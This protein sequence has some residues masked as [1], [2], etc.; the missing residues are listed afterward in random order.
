ML[1]DKTILVVDDEPDVVDTIAEILEACRVDTAGTYR[2]GLQRLQSGSYDLVI[3]DIMGVS[4]LD[5]LDAAVQRDIPAVM[6]TAPAISPE[7]LL[8][9][10]ER[11]AI[12]FIP[13]HDLADL[14]ELLSEL[15]TVVEN[16]Q[17]PLLHTIKRLEPLLDEFFPPD[18]KV[19]CREICH[20]R[21]MGGRTPVKSSLHRGP[22]HPAHPAKGPAGATRFPAIDSD[23]DR[24]MVLRTLVAA[25]AAFCYL[26]FALQKYAYILYLVPGKRLT[27]PLTAALPATVSLFGQ[28]L[29]QPL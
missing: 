7:Y 5:L 27:R 19:K 15:L 2:T 4:G 14:N 11:G 22:N 26:T 13:K 25:L 12:S 1:R 28:N 18:W 8:K 10:L 29:R 24:P 23:A 17:S 20:G 16:G 9:S 21:S 6:L 3:L